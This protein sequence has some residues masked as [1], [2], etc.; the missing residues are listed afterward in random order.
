MNSR[1]AGLRERRIVCEKE[2]GGRE[3]LEPGEGG[4]TFIGCK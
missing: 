3:I 1:G 2:K 4:Q